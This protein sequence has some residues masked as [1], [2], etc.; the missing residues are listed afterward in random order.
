MSSAGRLYIAMIATFAAGL[1]GIITLGSISLRAPLDLS[2]DWNL[3]PQD[4][5]NDVNAPRKISMQQSGRYSHVVFEGDKKTSYELKRT[6]EQRQSQAAGRDQIVVT[7]AG[8]GM[9]MTF[10]GM[11]PLPGEQPLDEYQLNLASKDG[12]SG[13]WIATRADS[14]RKPGAKPATQPAPAHG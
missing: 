13:S 6:V 2:G 9:E 3:T 4:G 5:P 1:W 11:A 10:T 14:T 7:L 12:P 8:D